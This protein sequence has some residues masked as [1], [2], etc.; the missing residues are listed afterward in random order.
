MNTVW[1]L[2]GLGVA[3]AVHHHVAPRVARQ[4]G[5]V[6]IRGM[7]PVGLATQELSIPH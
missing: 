2:I 1:V 6:G 7:G 5:L 3:L 4:A